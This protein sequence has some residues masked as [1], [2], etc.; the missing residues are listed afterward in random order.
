MARLPMLLRRGLLIH[1]GWVVDSDPERPAALSDAGAVRVVVKRVGATERQV[2]TYPA[3]E[4]V[5]VLGVVVDRRPPRT[6]AAAAL[7]GRA[8]VT[9]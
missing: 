4:T 3:R 6:G 5:P 7:L 8:Q 9:A 2:L 1:P